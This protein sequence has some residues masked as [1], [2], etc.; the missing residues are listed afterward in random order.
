M[1]ISPER[2]EARRRQLVDAAHAL[3]RD[4][5]GAGFSM[6][7]LA[8]RA[9][10][11]PATPYN[12][13]GPKS[14]VLRLVVTDIYDGFAARLERLPAGTPLR[15]LLDAVDL[16]AAYY[17]EDPGF[18]AGLYRT[19]QGADRAAIGSRM[20]AQGRA[21]WSGFVG[22]AVDA[23][24]LESFVAVEPLTDVLLRVMSVTTE[25]WLS[26]GWTPERFADEMAH[27]VRLTLA[28]VATTP[29]RE[30]LVGEVEQLQAVIAAG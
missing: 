8:V 13:V 5:G 20:F 21:L 7:Q 19:A 27:A 9:G 4:N 1:S 30:T 23:G 2:L 10:V 18:Y 29:G 22:A 16:V 28:A 11:S 14:E 17:A 26:L 15:R 3:I 6:A 25:F 12:L 24:E